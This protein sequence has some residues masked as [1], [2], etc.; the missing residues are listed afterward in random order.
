MNTKKYIL[1]KKVI[2]ITAFLLA[3]YATV[4]YSQY[5][6]VNEPIMGIYEGNWKCSDKSG[7]ITSQIRPIGDGM[8]DGFILLKQ[9]DNVLAVVKVKST[10]P[11]QGGVVELSGASKG[12]TPN[13]ELSAKIENGKMNGTISGD[14]GDGYFNSVKII[15]RSPTLGQKP[16]EGAVVLFDGKNTNQFKEFKWKLVEGDAMEIARGD[17]FFKGD[18]KNFKLH[19]EFRTPF[20]PKATGQGRGNSGV[21]LWSMYE[22]QVLDSFGIY[23]LANND[24]GSI[25]SVK[26]PPGNN[27]LPPMEWQTY[28]IIYRDG[29]GTP[30]NP[31]TITV[32]HNGVLTLENVKIPANMIGKGGAAATPGGGMLKLQDHGNPVQYRNIWLLPLKD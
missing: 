26:A 6:G 1:G 27:C 31:P 22:V 18:Y 19:I 14:F 28:D 7:N 10:K 9:K 11:A 23:P 29:D 8:Y 4:V 20:M 3:T 15:K 13:I 5:Y 17:V 16:P 25:Y 12:G 2:G 32:Y 21:Y 30:A 24:C